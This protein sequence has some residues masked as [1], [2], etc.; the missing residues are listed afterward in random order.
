[1]TST[2]DPLLAS[3]GRKI[4]KR[5]EELGM[6]ATELAI[7]A[8]ITAST[9]SLYESGQRAMGVDKLHRIAAILKVPLSY[10]QS[11][12]LDDDKYVLGSA[13]NTVDRS[14]SGYVV[15]G[16]FLTFFQSL[17]VFEKASW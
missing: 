6:T 1:M 8:D 7:Q 15:G 10:L 16:I 13:G 9:L 4:V 2:Y 14:Q 12:E 17:E 5:R 11:E 3:I